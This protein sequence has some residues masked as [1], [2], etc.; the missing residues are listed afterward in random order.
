MGNKVKLTMKHIEVFEEVV[1]SNVL[2]CTDEELFFLFEDALIEKK[3]PNIS[4]T[5]YKKYKNNSD[6]YIDKYPQYEE[7]F[8]KLLSVV[9]KA[10]IKE[11]IRCF[12][13]MHD[14]EEL[15]WQKWAW[16]IERKFKEWNLK[17]ISETKNENSNTNLNIQVED[18]ETKKGI[19]DM[20]NM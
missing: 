8:E 11:K 20:E 5:T 9:K 7:I 19:E 14:K 17:S 18:A 16:T 12:N 15:Q 6:D 10:L 1:N 4:Y 2:Y 13:K 3:L